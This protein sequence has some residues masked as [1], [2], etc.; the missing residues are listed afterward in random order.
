LFMHLLT[1]FRVA[2]PF[3]LFSVCYFDLKV[4]VDFTEFATQVC[5]KAL[6]MFVFSSPYSV[7]EM[8]DL[9][10]QAGFTRRSCLHPAL[11]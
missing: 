1:A 2:M 7:Y 9:C 10:I 3:P 8:P 11:G 4:T 6:I 5:R